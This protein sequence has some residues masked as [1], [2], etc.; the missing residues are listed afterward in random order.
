MMKNNVVGRSNYVK[1]GNSSQNLKR[2][3]LKIYIVESQISKVLTILPNFL[4]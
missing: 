1:E 3:F 4:A 2:I